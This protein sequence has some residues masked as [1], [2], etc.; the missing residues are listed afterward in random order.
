MAR[1]TGQIHSAKFIDIDEKVVEVLYGKDKESLIAYNV[2][3]DY[4]SQV[5]K[6]LLEELSIEEIQDQTKIYYDSIGNKVEESIHAAAKEMFEGWLVNV[7]ADLDKQDKERYAVFE[8][9]KKEEIEKID[10]EIEQRYKEA[11]QYKQDQ[12]VIL[13]AEVDKQVE[14]RFDQ[15]SKYQEEQLTVLQAE[16][17]AQVEQRYKEVDEYKQQQTEILEKE[18]E[19]NIEKAYSE[20]DQYREE[21]LKKAHTE[22]DQYREEQTKILQDELDQQ[23]ALRYKEADKYKESQVNILRAE[24]KEKFNIATPSAPVVTTDNV[25]KFLFEKESDEDTVFKA[26]L[27]VFNKP[28]VKN[29]VDRELK[30]KIRKAK[31]IPQL[32]AAYQECLI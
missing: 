3:V 29:N 22:V 21:S 5:F 13:Q 24:L 19:A 9:Y 4:N 2:P 1:F 25:I 12:L 27:A 8:Q 16:V 10:Q 14:E 32:F 23:V 15:V 18:V 31:T 17:D 26:K 28:E 11:D 20:V 6:D 30:M 7:Q